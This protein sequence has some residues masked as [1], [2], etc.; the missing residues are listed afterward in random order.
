ML[1]RYQLGQELEKGSEGVVYRGCHRQ[2]GRIVAIKLARGAACRELRLEREAPRFAPCADWTHPGIVQVYESGRAEHARYVVMELAPGADLRSYT[3]PEN[4]L[5]L[6]HLL[7][8]VGRVADALHHAHR[9]GIVHGDVKPQNI[10]FDPETDT[11]KIADFPMRALARGGRASQRPAGTP[12][13]RSP[14]QVC[15]FTLAPASDQFSLGVTLY[16]LACGHLPFSASSLPQLAYSIVHE[17]HEDIRARLPA[18]PA[19]LAAVIDRMLAKAPA[20]RYR[21]A[22]ELARA[23]RRI[24]LRP[25]GDRKTALR[26]RALS[27]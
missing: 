12:A 11:V 21:N 16:R 18:L 9:H 10:L 8:I 23:I 7:A 5:P 3:T 26:E 14:E 20:A 17:P 6:A 24:E 2:S 15:G 19:S 25:D 13:Y 1:D 27:R 22:D 4:L